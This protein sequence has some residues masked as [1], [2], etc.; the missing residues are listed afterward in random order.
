MSSSWSTFHSFRSNIMMTNSKF[1]QKTQNAISAE[2]VREGAS[3]A[4]TS[5]CSCTEK[6]QKTDAYQIMFKAIGRALLV[7]FAALPFTMF[8]WGLVDHF[9]ANFFISHVMAIMMKGAITFAVVLPIKSASHWAFSMES[10][11]VDG[12]CESRH[13]NPQGESARQPGPVL[14]KVLGPQILAA[15]GLPHQRVRSFSLHFRAGHPVTVD[16]EYLAYADAPLEPVLRQFVLVDRTTTE[17]AQA[18]G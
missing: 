12:V 6:S 3:S 10:P 4:V 17:P 7:A 11:C 9:S 2:S 14:S 15:L 5:G 16:V 13:R 8:G 1:A 18:V